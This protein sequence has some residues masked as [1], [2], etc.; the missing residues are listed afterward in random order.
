MKPSTKIFLILVLVPL[1]TATGDVDQIAAQQTNEHQEL[2]EGVSAED[3]GERAADLV[4]RIRSEIDAGDIYRRKLANAGAEDSL[5]FRL[6]IATHRV[7]LLSDIHDLADVL[8]DME[9]E[10]P[11]AELR[12]EV[13]E[14]CAFV[15]PLLW[16]HINDLRHEIDSFRNKRSTTTVQDRP[17]L[18]DRI[19]RLSGRLDDGFDFSRTHIEKLEKLGMDATAATTTY[20]ALMADRAGELSGRINFALERIDEL[21]ARLR[22]TPGNSDLPVLLV[23]A[24]KSLGTNTTSMTATLDLMD[25][26]KI[27]TVNYRAQL[28]TATRDISVGLLDSGVAVGLVKTMAERFM[29]WM[30]ENGPRLLLKGLLVFA[31][32]F[33]S[34][35]LAQLVKKGVGKTLDSSKLN[36]SRLLRRMIVTSASNAV[37]ILGL[38]IALSQMQISL[39]PLLAGLGVAGFIVGFALQDTLANFAAG[40]MILFYRP[41]DVG[42]MVEV[43]GVFGKVDRMSLV[44]TTILTI[45]NQTLV[46]PNN[47]IWG[48]VIKNVTAQDKRRV[49]M[50]FGIAYSDDIPKAEQ[51]LAGIL[52]QEDKV[53]DDPEPVVRLH[54]LG[55]SSVDFVVRPWAAVDD[56]WE[57]YWNVTRAV[58]MRFDEE[59]ISI[60]FPQRDVHIYEEKSP[61]GRK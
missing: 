55:E 16:P 32:L 30:A 27:H 36:V 57:V 1:L 51:V 24:H 25:A 19:T 39:G 21:D 54:T 41:Y 10:E 44:S 53:L 56:Y 2:L 8:V 35:L 12:A 13:E 40:M 58:K 49:D 15:T 59:G 34:R 5:V 22:D 9:K 61:A 42:D 48:D 29:T 31:I 60:P 50:V 20:K 45:D 47:K 11:R 3:L 46:V 37:M 43:G 38:L 7:Q 6:Q 4:L 23:A 14:L 26:F 33:I 28:V 17:A 52:E 18:E